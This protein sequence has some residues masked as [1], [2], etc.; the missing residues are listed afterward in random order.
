MFPDSPEPWKYFSRLKPDPPNLQ[1]QPLTKILHLPSRY[2]ANPDPATWVQA[3]MKKCSVGDD[4]L[5][6][7]S[8]WSEHILESMHECRRD[9]L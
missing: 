1:N 6:I 9:Q 7:R 2:S 5:M 8:F 4:M 3:N